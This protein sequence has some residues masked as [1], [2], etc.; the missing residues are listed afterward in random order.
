MINQLKVFKLKEHCD[1]NFRV[2]ATNIENHFS[3]SHILHSKTIFPILIISHWV[4]VLV[5]INF[6]MNRSYIFK[7]YCNF[8]SSKH[9]IQIESS[10]KLSI[11]FCGISFELRAL[12][13][14]A[15][16][17]AS[18]YCHCSLFV[19]SAVKVDWS[20]KLECLLLIAFLYI[21]KMQSKRS[22]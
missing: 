21:L 7:S 19:A 16:N 4:F 13:S 8:F 9:I 2:E 5:Y 14:L 6:L 3:Y 11:T 15:M 12:P 22:I 18:S 1:I 20:G 17:I 10:L